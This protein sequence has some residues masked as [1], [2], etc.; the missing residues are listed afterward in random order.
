MPRFPV[1]AFTLYIAL[2]I[3][4]LSPCRAQNGTADYVQ[5][6]QKAE[7]LMKDQNWSEAGPLW[8]QVTAKNPSVGEYWSQQG[9]AWYQAKE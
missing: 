4:P 7:R 3:G 8:E 1:L 6:L 2:S 5:L 9:R